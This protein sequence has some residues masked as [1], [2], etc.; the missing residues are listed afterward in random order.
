MAFML[1]DYR[2]VIVDWGV[3]NHAFPTLDECIM[4][5]PVIDYGSLLSITIAVSAR[6]MHTASR[7]E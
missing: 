6:L 7:Q 1:S 2:N 3:V 4:L 5:Q